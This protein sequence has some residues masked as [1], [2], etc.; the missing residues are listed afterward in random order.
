MKVNWFAGLE[1]VEDIKA[2]YR[3]LAMQHHPDRP[4]GDTAKMQDINEQY[5]AALKACHGQT[6]H[7]TE[8]KE[9]TYRYNYDVE[10]AVIDKLYEIL[11]IKMDA[12]VF[13]I[14][15]WIWIQGDTKP[16]KDQLKEIGCLW[17]GKRQMW[18][19]R[20]QQYRSKYSGADMGTLAWR[21]GCKEFQAS[22]AETAL[23]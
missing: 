20:Q 4:G 2:H 1:T 5:H 10:Q 9:H 6:S 14:G 21:Y 8:G 13:L 15:T 11:R 12:K 18:Y 22:D 19:W 16:V 7:D 3:R 17:H 23:A